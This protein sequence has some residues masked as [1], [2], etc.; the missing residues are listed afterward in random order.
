MPYIHHLS[1]SLIYEQNKYVTSLVNNQPIFHPVNIKFHQ[2]KLKRACMVMSCFRIFQEDEISISTATF[3]SMKKRSFMSMPSLI[4]QSAIISIYWVSAL[5]Q[6]V[7]RGLSQV[8]SLILEE[9]IIIAILKVMKLEF[10]EIKWFVQSAHSIK[11]AVLNLSSNTFF[12]V[13]CV[14][15]LEEYWFTPKWIREWRLYCSPEIAYSFFLIMLIVNE[16]YASEWI[17]E[18]KR[19]DFLKTNWPKKLL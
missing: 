10:T 13:F 2:L 3:M 1:W 18:W 8:I 4:G 5:Y 12:F 19:F 14:S 17:F 16:H 11:I 7:P 15:F 9:D 6:A